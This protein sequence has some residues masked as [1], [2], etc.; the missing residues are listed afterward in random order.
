MASIRLRGVAARGSRPMWRT[1]TDGS[2]LP[3]EDHMVGEMPTRLPTMGTRARHGMSRRACIV[4]SGIVV[5]P[6]RSP[7]VGYLDDSKDDEV[8]RARVA[9]TPSLSRTSAPEWATSLEPPPTSTA[10]DQQGNRRT[11][12]Y[13][14]LPGC[15]SEHHKGSRLHVQASQ[16][17][18]KDRNLC[19]Y[20][21]GRCR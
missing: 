7:W 4:G 19:R 9:L 18:P 20:V 15:K 3:V 16:F 14:E 8:T 21:C 2:G 10:T 11:I 1:A 17:K 12:Q 5:F 6:E 13:E